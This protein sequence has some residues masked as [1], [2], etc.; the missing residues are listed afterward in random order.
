[1]LEITRFSLE[2]H[3]GP[4]EKWPLKTRLV[5]DGAMLDLTIGGYTLLRQFET[6]AGY[7]LVTDYDCMYEE[8]ISFTLIDKACTRVLS[9]RQIGA[10]YQTYWLGDVIWKD[11]WRFEATIENSDVIASFTIRKFHIPGFYPQLGMLLSADNA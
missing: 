3:R 9:H 10:P 5:A 2:K 1:M 11:P 7:L 8:V 6:E 4:Y